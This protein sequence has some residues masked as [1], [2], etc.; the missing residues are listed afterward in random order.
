[1]NSGER[2]LC[3]S[4]TSVQETIELGRALGQSLV[5]G[6]TIGLTGPL[7]AGKTQ[8]IKGIAL[9]NGLKNDRDVTSPTFTLIHEYPGRLAL[10][11]LDAYRLKGSAEL[12]SLGFDELIRNDAAVVVE[13]ADRVLPAMPDDRLWIDIITTGEEQRA[14]TISAVGEIARRCITSFQATCR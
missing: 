3:R 8:L 7:G 6:L 5:G 2:Q 9:G 11:H 13:W 4:T 10:F 1:M 14:L 12:Q